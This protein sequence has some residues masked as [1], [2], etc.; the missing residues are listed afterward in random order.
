MYA[1][2]VPAGGAEEPPPPLRPPP[3]QLL[4]LEGGR[5]DV[6]GG[7]APGAKRLGA[8][9]PLVAAAVRA[10]HGVSGDGAAGRGTAPRRDPG[11]PGLGGGS[12]LAREG[13]GRET[14][15]LEEAGIGG[16]GAARPAVG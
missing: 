12:R 2:G 14:R 3:P 6:R 8:C 15:A 5:A 4:S 16:A 7:G 11:H 10:G 9:G 13:R 1:W